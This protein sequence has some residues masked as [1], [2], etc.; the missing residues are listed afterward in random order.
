MTLEFTHHHALGGRGA[1]EGVGDDVGEW[2]AVA[3]QPLMFKCKPDVLTKTPC[4]VTPY[5]YRLDWETWIHVTAI[6]EHSGPTTPGCISALI[7]RLLLGDVETA[8][9][10]RTPA[11][12]LFSN[13]RVPTA[14]RTRFYL[15]NYSTAAAL[16]TRGQ[17]WHRQALRGFGKVYVS[18]LLQQG[19]G[20]GGEGGGG[21]GGDEEGEEHAREGMLN[22]RGMPLKHR[23]VPQRDW[24]LFW[25]SLG[26]V[27]KLHLLH[28]R[29]S[30]PGSTLLLFLRTRPISASLWWCGQGG[31]VDVAG[32]AG[33]GGV[34]EDEGAEGGWR[35]MMPAAGW[36]LGGKVTELIELS[37]FLGAF[38]TLLLAGVLGEGGWEGE[39]TGGW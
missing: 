26:L 28:L 9:L 37:C 6:G 7:S 3:W 38:L 39:Q 27:F 11:S 20:G 13:G 10:L 15:Y 33:V 21:A 17:W 8:A 32:R 30:S 16:V 23:G 29:N 35:Q 31:R 14:I 36:D 5:H 4:F 2:E 24:A 12:Q 34:G 22:Y 18:P 1:Q 19:E 25:L